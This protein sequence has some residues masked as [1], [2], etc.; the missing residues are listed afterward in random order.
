M[1][2][3]SSL[4]RDLDPKSQEIVCGHVRARRRALV[5]VFAVFLFMALMSKWIGGELGRTYVLYV[6][7]VAAFVVFYAEM[8]RQSKRFQ[9][10][11][12]DESE[13]SRSDGR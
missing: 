3:K 5:I 2:R 11:I 1:N 12:R 6:L 10:K 13:A 4:H 9:V 7:A 8:K